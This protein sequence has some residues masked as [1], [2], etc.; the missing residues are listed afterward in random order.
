MTGTRY[1]LE[2]NPKLPS[3]LARL[4]EL[5][6]N[7]WYSWDRPTRA[8]FVRLGNKLW[9]AVGHSPK[10]SLKRLDQHRLDEAAE[11]PTYLGALARVLSAYDTYHTAPAREHGPRLPEG[12]LVAYFCAEFGFHE[13]LPIYSGGLGI[14]AGD[15]CKTASDLN[16]PFIGMG[17]LYRQGYFQQTI[18]GGGHQHAE[19]HDADFDDLPIAP[20]LRDDGSELK[21]AVPLTGREV[22]AKVWKTRVGHVT[23]YLLDTDLEENTPHDRDIVDR[24][25]VV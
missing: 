18:D 9:G 25:S 8:L 1:Q 24:K 15:H 10:A 7:L 23:L 2:V 11:D 21:V 12:E 22:L 3:R 14:L 19:Y 6:N 16:L 5:A 17:L 4:D 20:V 13:S